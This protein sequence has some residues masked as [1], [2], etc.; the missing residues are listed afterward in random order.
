MLIAA[1]SSLEHIDLQGNTVFHYAASSNKDIILTLGSD[2]PNRLN[3]RNTNGETPLHVACR[4]NKPDCVKALLL[5]G[6]DVNIS[7][8]EEAAATA[9]PGYVGDYINK[10]NVFHLDDIKNGGTP[11]HWALSRE[12]VN[13]LIEK[14]CN[15]D[16][17]NFDGRTALHIMVLRKRL[18]C[19]VALLSHMANVNIA[20]REG[21][22]PLHMAV[23]KPSIPIIQ[24]LIG[25]GA[26]LNVCNF[27]GETPRHLVKLDLEGEKI[28]YILHVV[29]AERCS[30]ETAECTL[31]CKF[32]ES[33][34]GTAPPEPP[35][36]V[37]RTVLDQML[38]VEG[39]EKMASQTRRTKACRL[40]C[41]DGGGI[42][43]LVLIQTL[44]ELELVLARPILHC[45]DW[46]AGT[47]T[48]GILAL[49]LASGKSLKEL[50]AL[51]FRIKEETFVG[52]R[53]Y[54]SEP[55]EKVLQ[56]CLGSNTTMSDIK[57]PKLMITGVLADR[58]PVD[59]HL[60]R[61]YR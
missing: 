5:I 4:N 53:P 42:R 58:K 15:V 25:F 50:Q 12:V 17:L 61:N 6:A 21:N 2:L 43:G 27:K 48:G 38:Y 57:H 41:L 3:S 26:D 1:K 60:F 33:W 52:G 44:L 47:S 22:T 23:L 10:S 46:I 30:V 24:I 8:D 9:R 18:D 54:S 39:M 31:G 55:L 13:V 19:I 11:L 32:N 36:Q 7:S 49:G 51:Y 56:D 40:L 34:N 29:G 45:F 59:L 37:P 14:N 20:D 28:L 35:S 16:A